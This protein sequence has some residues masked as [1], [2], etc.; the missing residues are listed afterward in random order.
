LRHFPNTRLT[1]KKNEKKQIFNRLI[2]K[3]VEKIWTGFP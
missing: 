2:G 3:V 1:G